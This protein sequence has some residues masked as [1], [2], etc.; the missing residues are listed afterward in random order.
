[1]AGCAHAR[2]DVGGTGSGPVKIAAGY[3]FAPEADPEA[4]ADKA[5]LPL[6]EARLAS[7]GLK[8]QDEGSRYVVE[9]GV[10]ARPL[11]VGAFAGAAPADKTQAP[12]WL[13]SPGKPRWWVQKPESI[14]ALSLRFVDTTNGAEAYRV[15]AAQ[16]WTQTECASAAPHLLDIALANFPSPPSAVKK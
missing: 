9:V 16:Q 15:H 3:R 11:Q 14:C 6:V 10:T 7:L 1:M 2:F 13:T 4:A 12:D 8:R 5:V